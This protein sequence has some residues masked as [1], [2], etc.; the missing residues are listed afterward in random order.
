MENPMDK[1][2]KQTAEEAEVF[3]EAANPI[4]DAE[5][6]FESEAKLTEERVNAFAQV[7]NAIDNGD[8]EKPFTP[9]KKDAELFDEINAEVEAAN[10]MDNGWEK[11]NHR[12]LKHLEERDDPDEWN[13][14]T[15]VDE[16]IKEEQTESGEEALRDEIVNGLEGM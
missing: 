11:A 1:L 14:E 6:S 8:G 7:Q 9:P 13:P 5:R 10:A 4:V 2:A 12:K 16:K 3:T 15:V